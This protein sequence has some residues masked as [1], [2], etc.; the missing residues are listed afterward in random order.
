MCF[1]CGVEGHPAFECPSYNMQESKQGQQ[2]SLNFVQA[3]NEEGAESE[4]PPDMGESLMIWRYWGLLK[5]SKGRV[6][7]MKILGFRQIFFEPDVLPGE[8]Y[9]KLLLI[10]AIVRIWFPKR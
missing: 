6:A 1:R 8:R 9:V 2:P 7:T 3:E 4:V 10:V 5:K